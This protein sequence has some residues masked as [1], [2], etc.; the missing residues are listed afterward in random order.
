M[1]R[2]RSSR[3]KKSFAGSRRRRGRSVQMIL[4]S[5]TPS[6]CR[7]RFRDRPI[8]ARPLRID[9]PTR[10]RPGRSRGVSGLEPRQRS[11]AQPPRFC[12]RARSE[13]GTRLT[14]VHAARGANRRFGDRPPD[15]GDAPPSVGCPGD[16]LR[17]VR[18]ARAVTA[19][20]ALAAIGRRPSVVSGPHGRRLDRLRRGSHRSRAIEWI[21]EQAAMFEHSN[22]S[23]RDGRRSHRASRARRAVRPNLARRP[24]RPPSPIC[25]SMSRSSR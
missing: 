3:R 20:P 21:R 5:T 15:R 7:C 8:T 6:P 9:A 25:A 2:D 10:T 11:L 12:R 24:V 23:A 14:A 17:L 4:P 13:R 19:K 18:A 1:R 22:G 16:V